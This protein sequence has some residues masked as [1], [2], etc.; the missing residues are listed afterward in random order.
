MHKTLLL[1][2]KPPTK[3]RHRLDSIVECVVRMYLKLL[4]FRTI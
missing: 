2:T 3:I 4:Q 1:K